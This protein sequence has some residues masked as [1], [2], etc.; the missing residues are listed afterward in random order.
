MSA[1]H[2]CPR[3]GCKLKVERVKVLVE[4]EAQDAPV[5][6]SHYEEREEISDCVRCTGAY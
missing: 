6:V 4:Q 3:C 2:K 1:D 5:T